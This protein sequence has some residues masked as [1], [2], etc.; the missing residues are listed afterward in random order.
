MIRHSERFTHI[1]Y[2]AADFDGICSAAIAWHLRPARAPAPVLVP[3]DYGWEAG[4]VA[5]IPDGARVLMADFSLEPDGM[6]E[7]NRR[8]R[9]TLCDHH[10]P[11]LRELAAAGFAASGGGLTADHD[12]AGCGLVWRFLFGDG[13]IMPRIVELCDAYDAHREHCG[14][15]AAVV[16]PFQAG[17]KAAGHRD[18]AS[19][20]WRH[21]LASA[22]PWVKAYVRDGKAILRARADDDRWLAGRTAHPAAIRG[23]GGESLRALVA[24]LYC[25]DPRALLTHPGSAEADLLVTYGWDGRPAWRL[26]V[27]P[28]PARPDLDAAELC[29]ALWGGGGHPGRAGAV[30]PELPWAAAR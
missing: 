13:P 11:R 24:N 6:L 30:L 8:V 17:L 25:R 12:P 27:C 3:M 5:A 9:L 26:S 15:W 16:L 4:P 18:P 23:P 10:T 28:G 21:L 22:T 2:H 1:V 29:R 19:D 20:V 14:E 7:L